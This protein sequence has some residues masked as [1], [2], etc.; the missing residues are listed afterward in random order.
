[1]IRIGSRDDDRREVLRG[2]SWVTIIAPELADR[3]RGAR[4]LAASGAFCEVSALPNGSLWLRATRTI[5]EFTA[6]KI[7]QVFEALA[8][9]L[10]TGPAIPEFSYAYR[11]VDD[12]DAADYQ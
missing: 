5:N 12:V 10:L 6:D 7:H 1:M 9:V 11:I 8:P 3:L 2:Y 4:S